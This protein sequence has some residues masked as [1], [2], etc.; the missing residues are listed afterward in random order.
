MGFYKEIN[1]KHIYAI[2]F[3]ISFTAVKDVSYD[4]YIIK[5]M[6]IVFL[7]KSDVTLILICNL[8]CC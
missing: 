6:T 7:Y 3:T 8:R 5:V 2:N 4:W 1:N